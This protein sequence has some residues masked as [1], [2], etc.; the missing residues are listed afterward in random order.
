MSAAIKNQNDKNLR[1][2]IIDECT[3][4]IKTIFKDDLEF[5]FIFGFYAKNKESLTCS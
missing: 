3:N 4:N 5:S 1:N 2:L